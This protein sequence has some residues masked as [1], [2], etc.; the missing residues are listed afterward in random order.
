[1]KWRRCFLFSILQN[2]LW[3]IFYIYTLSKT[4][5]AKLATWYN[6]LV[7]TT[8]RVGFF[9]DIETAQQIVGV[10]TFEDLCT[11][12]LC[13]KVLTVSARCAYYQQN[14]E[15]SHISC[16]PEMY[17]P[18][19]KPIHIPRRTVRSGPREE[20]YKYERVLMQNQV[21][22]VIDNVVGWDNLKWKMNDSFFKNKSHENIR[23]EARAS[24][25]FLVEQR[26]DLIKNSLYKTNLKNA[27]SRKN[28][29]EIISNF[30]ESRREFWTFCPPG[31]IGTEFIITN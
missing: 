9:V 21:H 13:T 22:E 6:K 26:S 16:F 25:D 19:P 12:Q 1:M 27:L 17:T 20:S 4:A 7:K 5:K 30:V 3:P 18:I 24:V 29:N 15:D 23:I 10:E 11:R 31:V 28:E 8:A 2:I 14:L